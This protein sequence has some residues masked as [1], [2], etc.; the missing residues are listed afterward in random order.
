MGVIERVRMRPARHQT[1]EVG[2]VHH[3]PRAHLVGD[4]PE[5][6]EID[7]A[8]IGRTASDDQLR[9]AF[10]RE[11]LDLVI[12]DLVG[13][14]LD[15]VGHHLEPL[16]RLVDRGAVGEMAAGG[17]VEAHVGVAGLEQREEHRLIG[18]RARVRLHVGIRAV[19]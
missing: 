10:E 5:A 7:D 18:L 16:A 3:E 15:H 8:R 11:P 12:I 2:H 6:G 9:L 14:G 19:E 4:G 1:G 13:V 17:E